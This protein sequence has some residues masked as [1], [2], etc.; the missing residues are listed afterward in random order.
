MAPLAVALS[1]GE[2]PF[3]ILISFYRIQ[4]RIGG[5]WEKEPLFYY[6]QGI[7]ERSPYALHSPFNPK[8]WE[9]YNALRMLCTLL[10]IILMITVFLI[11]NRDIRIKKGSMLPLRGKGR[12]SLRTQGLK[13]KGVGARE[14]TIAILN[15]N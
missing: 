8:E 7:G 12:R 4:I 10:P 9:Y 2:G 5:E 14:R 13:S 15:I 1:L 6:F 11:F 3:F